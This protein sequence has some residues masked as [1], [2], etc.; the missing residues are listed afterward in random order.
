MAVVIEEDKLLL[1]R[2]AKQHHNI[3]THA[4]TEKN[5]IVL[6][7]RSKREGSEFIIPTRTSGN[8]HFV[9][10]V[11]CMFCLDPSASFEPVPVGVLVKSGFGP[12][13]GSGAAKFVPI[14]NDEH[15][16]LLFLEGCQGGMAGF[17]LA[18]ATRTHRRHAHVCEGELEG[19]IHLN[20]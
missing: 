15:R 13:D 16:Q 1:L 20:C 11:Y 14:L 4:I 2:W 8:S 18:F 9:M 17:Q 19:I 3:P 5:L 7:R 10:K 6:E 12:E